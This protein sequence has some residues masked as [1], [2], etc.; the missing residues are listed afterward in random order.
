MAEWKRVFLNPGRLGILALLTVLSA[1]LFMGSLMQRIGPGEFRRALELGKYKGELTEKWREEEPSEILALSEAEE[2][3]LMDYY[4]YTNGYTRWDSEGNELPPAFS[5]QEEADHAI[6][7]MEYLLSLKEDESMFSETLWMYIDALHEVEADAEYIAGYDEYLQKIQKQAEEQ[8][9][10]SIFGKKNSFSMRNLKKTA[11]EFGKLLGKAEEGSDSSNNSA[12]QVSFGNNT[13]IEKWLQF[14]LGDYFGLLF[15][16]IIVMSFLEERKKG[17]WSMIRT[18]KGGRMMLGLHRVGILLAA[19]AGATLL[20]NVLPLFLS[21]RLNGGHTDLSRAIQSVQSFRTCTIRTTIGGWLARYFFMKALSGLFLGLFI[22]FIMGS[23]QNS[24]LSLAALLPVLGGEYALFTFLP[25]QSV[26]NLFKYLNLFS[27]V[28][29]TRLY[30]NYLNIDLFSFPVG[31]RRMMFVL[32][33]ILLAGFL[34]L[35]VRMQAKRYPEG[36]RDLL[37]KIALR[38]NAVLDILRS[39]FTMSMWEA[40]KVLI[41]QYGIV[42]MLIMLIAS[43]SLNF[44]VWAPVPEDKRTY[45]LYVQDMQ[46]PIDESTDDYLKRA[47]ESAEK[48]GNSYELTAALEL[49]EEKVHALR[50]KGEKEGF[51][52]WMLYDQNFNA[53]YGET[54]KDR[55]RL[56]AMIAM[57]FV[58]FLCAGITSYEKQAGVVL[59]LRSLQNGRRKLL[60]RKVMMALI[61]SVFAWGCVYLREAHQFKELFL[62]KT[63]SAGEE[64]VMREFLSAPIKNL[65]NYADFPFNIS[66]R[67]FLI[68]LNTMRLLML[69]SLSFAV[70]YISSFLPNVRMAYLVNTAVLILPALFTVLG[71]GFFRWISPLIPVSAAEL[72]LGMGAGKGWYIIPFIIWLVIG[73]GVLASYCK[74]WITS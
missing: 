65:D 36:N 6:S 42:M 10:T 73:Q 28:H 47:R 44:A 45:Y 62:P 66:I 14:T 71:I 16:I 13:G 37:S 27:Y 46:G 20:F 52:P 18:T 1:A 2:S 7:H 22:W 26:F 43:R 59:M 17:L 11:K 68:L 72:L 34:F 29:T 49:L 50:E 32:L 64:T 35:C 69:F 40:Y 31:N 55:Q 30:T 58:V 21:F 24:Q 12:V 8:S 74:K 56:N 39:R 25:V 67:G 57:L 38:V 41:L 60:L 61:L 19:S 9:K 54:P 5:S 3:L 15:L 4:Y 63:R 51:D 33:P 53:F 48:S 70:L 23:V